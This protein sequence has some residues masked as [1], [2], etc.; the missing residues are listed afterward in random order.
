MSA[1]RG[2]WPAER[3]PIV[4]APEILISAAR[5]LAVGAAVC[6]LIA[7]GLIL[8]QRPG[9]AFEGGG[10]RFPDGGGALAAPAPATL[11]ARDGARLAYRLFPAPQDAPLLIL[12]HGSG[13]HGLYYAD[14][15]A[16]LAAAGAATVLLPDLRG[17]GES[18]AAAPDV[19]HIGQLEEDIADLA[20][21]HLRPGQSL[22]LAGHSSGG[23]LAIR[24]A[25]GA[26]DPRPDGVVL[27]AP[28]LKYN[29][30]TMRAHSGGWA[31][32][33]T[34]RIVGLSMLNAVGIRALN[35]LTAIE[36]NIPEDLRKRP[37]GALMTG[38]YS[39]RLNASYPPRSDYLKDIKALPPFLLIAGAEDEAFRADRFA[40]VMAA[41]NPGGTY[42]VLPGVSHLQLIDAPETLPLMGNYLAR[43]R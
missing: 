26:Q 29:A 14:L 8:S 30:P 28:F 27:L 7:G 33:L 16:R 35:G 4:T 11:R 32:P 15:A 19:T 38:A 21:A 40:P 13:A 20:R 41:A 34:R 36:F 43:F 2:P 39:F 3:P 5:V 18:R 22:V 17:H 9:A 37:G 6:L 12:I 42:H 1:P 10:L 23:G 24:Y 31:R 25:G